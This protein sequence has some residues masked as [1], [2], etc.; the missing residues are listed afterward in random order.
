MLARGKKPGRK[1]SARSK[2]RNKKT[3]DMETK[4]NHVKN[5]NQISHKLQLR[6][7]FKARQR[8]RDMIFVVFIVIFAVAAYSGYYLYYKNLENDKDDNNDQE[9]TPNDGNTDNGNINTKDEINWQ[10][11][12]SGMNNA[13]NNN[14]PV[15][16]DFYAD[17]CGPCKNMDKELY[18]D[19][20]VIEKSKSFICIKVNGD[21]NSDLMNE[22]GV[23]SY[24]TIV[25]L[26]S[27]QTE[28]DRWVGWGYDVDNQIIEFLEY[29]DDTL[30]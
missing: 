4:T 17:W 30:N 21:Y 22:Y 5:N 16:I 8:K 6:A 26:D 15:L 7:E 29:M 19:S 14:K 24:P 3:E 23:D 13:K 1:R 9:I 11:Y 25:F 18:T 20:R 12:N 28:V 27:G 2:A 10:T